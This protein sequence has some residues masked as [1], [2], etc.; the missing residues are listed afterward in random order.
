MNRLLAIWRVITSNYYVVASE[1]GITASTP[2]DNSLP[3]LDRLID[4]YARWGMRIEEKK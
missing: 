1:T 4:L 3:R 2:K